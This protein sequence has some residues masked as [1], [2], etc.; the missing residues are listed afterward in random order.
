MPE[1]V[2]EELEA[3]DEGL[4][5]DGPG[6]DLW[7]EKPSG[8]V[9]GERQMGSHAHFEVGAG[10]HNDGNSVWQTQ[11]V[12]GAASCCCTRGGGSNSTPQVLHD[13]RTYTMAVVGQLW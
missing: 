3:A 6:M 13:A 1:V 11:H 4:H 8:E 9:Q 12:I 10:I 7:W 5:R 2:V